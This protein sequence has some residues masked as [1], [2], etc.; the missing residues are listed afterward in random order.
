MDPGLA[1]DLASPFPHAAQTVAI[2]DRGVIPGGVE[3]SP[4]VRDSQTEPPVFHP[5]IDADLGS[6]G[7]LQHVV[8]SLFEDEEDLPPRIGS[9]L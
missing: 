4:I 3:S 8:H 1:A 5:E 2:V 6:A 7:M 9:H